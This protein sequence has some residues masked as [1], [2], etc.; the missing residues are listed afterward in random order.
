MNH[1]TNIEIRTRTITWT[2]KYEHKPHMNIG[3]KIKRI[4]FE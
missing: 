2:L 3:S 4:E 1:D